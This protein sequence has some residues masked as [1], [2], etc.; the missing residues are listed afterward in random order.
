MKTPEEIVE[1]IIETLPPLK[2]PD[3]KTKPEKFVNVGIEACIRLFNDN[4]PQIIAAIKSC[5]GS[6]GNSIFAITNLDAED[7]GNSI[8]ATYWD[9][10]KAHE[11]LELIESG[12]HPEFFAGG[13]LMVFE[14]KLPQ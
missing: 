13:T 6:I 12:E 4:K 1:Q 9:N 10:E 8:I 11:E 5:Q 7:L 3:A 2:V 14:I